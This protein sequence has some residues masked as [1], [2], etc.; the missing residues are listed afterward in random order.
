M[1][2]AKVTLVYQGKEY[3]FLDEFAYEEEN[4]DGVE[5]NWKE[6]NFACDCNRSKYISWY[7][8]SGFPQLECGTTIELISFE[9]WKNL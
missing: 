4:I 9:H 8:Y 5:F 3:S 2:R 1:Y 7:C 6:N